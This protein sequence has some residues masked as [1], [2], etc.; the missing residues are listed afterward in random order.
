[1]IA[2]R[3]FPCALLSIALAP[4]IAAAQPH[5]ETVIVTLRA[6]PGAETELA[7]VLR[8][9][10]SAARALNLVAK[11]PHMRLRASEDG[12]KTCFFE[13]FSWRDA[14]IPDHAPASI[15]KLWSRM[16]ALVESRE[17]RPGLEFQAASLVPPQ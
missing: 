4:Q 1:M 3:L 8:Q 13:I 17:G 16:N 12:N 14:A 15:Q 6:K 5:P 11:A 10:W 9:H 2:R 7:E